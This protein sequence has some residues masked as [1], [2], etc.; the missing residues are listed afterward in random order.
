MHTTRPAHALTLVALL[1]VASPAA[2]AT[3]AGTLPADGLTAG[4]VPDA[5]AATLRPPRAQIDRPLE[6]DTLQDWAAALSP[7]NHPDHTP[8]RPLRLE[9]VE[10]AGEPGNGRESQ[11][12]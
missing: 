8:W 4:L 10:V 9:P 7:A 12:R 5:L 3:P 1:L 2:L 6:R 11:E